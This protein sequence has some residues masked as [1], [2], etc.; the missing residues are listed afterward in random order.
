MHRRRDRR[1][2][3]RA[4]SIVLLVSLIT[5]AVVGG[6]LALWTVAR[7]DPIASPDAV[8]VLGGAGPERARLGAELHERYG[9]PLVLSSSARVFGGELGYPCPPAICITTHP[10]TTAGEARGVAR[11]AH[12]NGWGGV[13]VVTT[14]FHTARA[15]LL[16]RQCLGDRVSVVGAPRPDGDGPGLR[17]RLN[18]IAGMVAGSTVRRAC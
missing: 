1:G 3:I 10:E 11:L 17:R 2:R 4:F 6:T 12:K 8:V 9:V 7:D 13:V 18:E 16:F 15:R 14:D 5:L